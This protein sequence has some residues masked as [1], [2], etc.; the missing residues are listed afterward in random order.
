MSKSTY[1]QKLSRDM[2]IVAES[3]HK[4]TIAKIPPHDIEAEM[5]V[6]GGMLI[7]TNPLHIADAIA[8]LKQEMFY[9]IIHGCVFETIR[10][11]HQAQEPIDAVTVKDAVLKAQPD[12]AF[13]D[14]IQE[15]L[16]SFIEIVPSAAN[17][18]HYAGIVSEKWRLR[19]HLRI[20]EEVGSRAWQEDSSVE[21][22]ADTQAALAEIAQA[23]RKEAWRSARD[24]TR[25]FMDDLESRYHL[26]SSGQSGMSGLTTGFVDLDRMCGGFQRGFLTILAARPS[27]GKSSL[28]MEMAIRQAERGASVAMF[29]LEMPSAGLTQ[30]TV[31]S[32]SRV[33]SEL[34]ARGEIDAEQWTEVKIA[35]ARFWDMNL[36]IEDEPGISVA[37][38]E[39]SL[40]LLLMKGGIDVVYIDYL[41]LIKAEVQHGEST[42]TAIGNVA[43]G[44]KNLARR[45]DVPIIALSQLNRGLERRDDKRPMLSDLRD[46]GNIEEHADQVLFIYRAAYYARKTGEEQAE[47]DVAEVLVSKNRNGRTGVAQLLFTPAFT[48]FDNYIEEQY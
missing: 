22:T 13:A 45:F 14:G 24:L 44:L 41:G 37:Q 29:S 47:H 7:A 31:S 6:L 38:I 1:P 28:M 25:E 21:I 35:A 19:E 3:G 39:A 42:A 46:S 17:V 23:N 12:N 26:A 43:K 15:M 2:A 48:R 5:S 30:R 27:M 34:I 20:A 8:L 32:L 10:K 18:A 9:R 33:N 40:R 4:S 11:M 36:H 16:L